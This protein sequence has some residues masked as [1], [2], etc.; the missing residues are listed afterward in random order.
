MPRCLSVIVLSWGALVSAYAREIDYRFAAEAGVEYASGLSYDHDLQFLTPPKRVKDFRYTFLLSAGATLDF[1][2]LTI[3]TSYTFDQRTYDDFDLFHRRRHDAIILVT[4][5]GPMNVNYGVR[6]RYRTSMP[7]GALGRI[8]S[9]QL[10][11]SADFPSFAYPPAAVSVSSSTYMSWQTTDFHKLRFLDS[12]TWETGGSMQLTPDTGAWHIDA[13]I[14]YGITDARFNFAS[15]NYA[16]F[17]LTLTSGED[18]YWEDS[19]IGPVALEFEFS[20]REEWY[21]G[22]GSDTGT[23]RHDR[24]TGVQFAARRDLTA[25]LNIFAEAAFDDHE[26][27]W[28][29]QNFDEARIQLGLRFDY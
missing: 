7:E 18:R 20:Y 10:R 23:Q 25:R 13:S 8:E 5:K 12:E 15:N 9:D 19:W 6:Y 17:S 21:E 1:D 11:F 4:A 24:I 27:N 16:D 14:A 29:G 2:G 28:G 26:S 22:L 3:D